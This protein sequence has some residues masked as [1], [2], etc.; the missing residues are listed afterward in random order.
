MTAKKETSK[1]HHYVPQAY[2]RGFATEKERVMVARLPGN[3]APF[4]TAVRNVGAQTPTGASP[5]PRTGLNA[6]ARRTFWR[7]SRM[8][9]CFDAGLH[10]RQRPRPPLPSQSPM[11]PSPRSGPQ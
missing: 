1:L 3:G 8:F 10:P 2:L 9:S 5:G 11:T 4:T 7:R 6:L